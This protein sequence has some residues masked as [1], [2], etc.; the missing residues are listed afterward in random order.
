MEISLDPINAPEVIAAKLWL[1]EGSRADSI[2]Q[3]GAHQLL[4]SLL[5]R[6]CGPYDSTALADLVE[7]CGAGL[8]CDTHEDGILISLKC[9]QSDGNQLLPIL[10]WMMMDPHLDP[11][12]LNLERE[13]SLQALQRQKENPFHLAFDG[14]RHLAYKNGPYGHDPLGL[15]NDLKSIGRKELLPLAEKI[16]IGSPILSISGSLEKNIIESIQ[17]ME[18]FKNL[19]KQKG[20]HINSKV[21]NTNSE[22]KLSP[23]SNIS[24]QSEPVEQIVLILGQVTIPHGHEDDLAIRL[25]SCHLGS[26]MSSLLFKKLREEHGVA[27]DVGVHFP[28]R[29][30]EAPFLLHASTTQEK[31]LKT[32][33]LLKQIWWSL[34]QQRLS[35]KEMNLARA[36][37]KGQLAHSSQ[38]TG[39]RA[40]R[41]AQ[42]RA[43]NLSDDY[44]KN[45]LEQIE[46]ITSD[47]LQQT[48]A[49]HL[50]KPLLSLCGPEKALKQLSRNWI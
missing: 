19:L 14:W 3:K 39:Q 8:R 34:S 25:L 10:G 33:D 4:G 11:K 23:S 38:T 1:R 46:S 49:R 2:G 29:E 32:L 7:G 18:P 41:K 15:S 26:G 16:K 37:F 47:Q 50:T 42:L 44:D 28:P 31:A 12:Q 5:S 22:Y 43:F 35:D 30:M 9:A 36:K 40:E 24:L 27:Y 17:N 48:A 6:G 13:L 21:R 45:S 20:N